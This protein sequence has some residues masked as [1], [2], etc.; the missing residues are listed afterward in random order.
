MLTLW[1]L[2]D[3]EILE[4][5]RKEQQAAAEEGEKCRR[6]ESKGVKLDLSV[7][8]QGVLV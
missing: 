8:R 5:I 2:I 6:E 1:L 4:G 3:P 7:G